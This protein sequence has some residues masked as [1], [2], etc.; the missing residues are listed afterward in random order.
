MIGSLYASLHKNHPLVDSALIR[1]ARSS[2]TP[3][4][5]Y[6]SVDPSPVAW[7]PTSQFIHM[8]GNNTIDFWYFTRDQ[9]RH[10]SGWFVRFIPHK[11]SQWF[12]SARFS[13]QKGTVVWSVWFTPHKPDPTD[14]SV[15]PFLGY[16]KPSS[17]SI[18]YYCV[19]DTLDIESG[20]RKPDFSV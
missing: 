17:A 4:W 8:S 12:Q 19:K 2:H 3:N 13:A 7:K 14:Q 20:Y 6:H 11:S 16:Q 10:L 18:Y 1:S 9:P 5:L 15:D